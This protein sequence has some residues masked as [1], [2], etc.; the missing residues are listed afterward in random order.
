MV[1]VVGLICGCV[2]SGG[3]GGTSGGDGG[4]PAQAGS[5]GA[6][7]TG[8]GLG[9]SVSQG[10]QSSKAGSAGA[11]A[12]GGSSG[13]QG[14]AS[15]AGGSPEAEACAFLASSWCDKKSSCDREDFLRQYGKK[16]VCSERQR[17]ACLADLALPGVQVISSDIAV[18]ASSLSLGSC[19]D[20]LSRKMA[21]SCTPPGTYASGAVCGHS[22]QC[23]SGY[24]AV[25]DGQSCGHC[26]VPQSKGGAC[27]VAQDCQGGLA[28]SQGVCEAYATLG[29]LCSKEFTTCDPG[30]ECVGVLSVSS[31]CKKQPLL[32]EDCDLEGY[33]AATQC[34]PSEAA[35]C[36]PQ[37]KKCLAL[38]LFELGAKCG[39]GALCEGG[40]CNG[41]V[42]Q[43]RVSEGGGCS[44]GLQCQEPAVCSGGTCTLSPVCKLGFWG[45]LARWWG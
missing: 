44:N 36:D 23:K 28:C 5:T 6:G 10:G 43:V 4:S 39:L 33:A 40:L 26:Q 19:T 24:C 42:C 32:G 20:F 15:G 34:A 29:D 37:T 1:A 14:G 3:T 16:S 7:N 21:A 8:Q 9:G 13:G 27:T 30:S 25:K 11:G 22:W 17:L 12:T 45:S 35:Y 38:Q 31:T 18:C 2:D 41:T